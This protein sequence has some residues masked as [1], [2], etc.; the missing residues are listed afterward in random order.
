MVN[1][2]VLFK[3]KTAYGMRISGWS[4]DVCSS[5]LEHRLAR[6]RADH[7][8]DDAEGR[9]D[10]DVDLRMAEEPEQVEEQDRVAAA[11]RIEERRAEVAV[12][13]QHG[14]GAAEH[15]QRQQQQEGGDQHGPGDRSEE[16][17]TELRSIMRI[18]SAGF[19]LKK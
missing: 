13:Q 14:D 19:C 12:G 15:R 3:Q 9:E 7:V 11:G 10:H 5:D 18:N 1:R 4:S 16:H 2:V 6:E 8:A 17:T